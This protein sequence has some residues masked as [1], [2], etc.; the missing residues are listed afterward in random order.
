[1]IHPPSLQKGDTIAIVAPAGR[2]DS[3]IIAQAGHRIAQM[4]YRVKL[5]SSLSRHHY[6]F[7][8]TDYNRRSDFQQMMDDDEVKAI[9]C[10]RGGYGAIRFVDELDFTGILAHPKW[11]IGFSDITVLHAA[12]L[13]QGLAT[14][15]GPMCKSFLNYTET[16]A[17]IEI[18]FS[19]LQ[20]ESPQYMIN[21]HPANRLGTT[22]GSLVGGNLSLLMALRGTRYD[23]DPRG[24]ILFIEDVDEY[25]YHLDR[26][27]LNLKLGGVLQKL[28]GLVVGQFT[29]MKDNETPFGESIEEIIYKNVKDYNYPVAFNFPAGHVETN[30]PLIFGEETEL[31]VKEN[32]VAL[33]AL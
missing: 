6:N 21:T 28:S 24:K 14:I 11:L 30:Y 27:M 13:K 7:S 12:F 26:M 3:A 33:V 22:K 2:I 17:D 31:V 16:G 8:S 29:D 4:G 18:L 9:L 15:H 10:T 19:F 20:G 5:G 32:E 1:M 25:L 23:F